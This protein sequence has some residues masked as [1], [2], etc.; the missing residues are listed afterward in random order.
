MSTR[1]TPTDPRGSAR[2]TAAALHREQERGRRRRAALVQG[3]V[4]LALV[5]VVLVATVAVLAARD[6]AAEP[7]AVPSGVGAD[8]TVTVGS[9]DAPVT[10]RLVEDF[11][12]PACGAFEAAVGDQLDTWVESGQVQVEHRPIAFLDRASTTEYSSRALGVALAVLE[13]AGPD[14]YAEVHDLLFASQPPEGGAGLDDERLVDLAVRAGA[15]EAAVAAAAEERPYDAWI[16]EATEAAFEDGVTGT[17]TVL[18]DGEE[19]EASPQALV[20]AVEAALAS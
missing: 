20:A 17:P 6:R 3:G 4:V 1:S 13:D 10:V 18:V 2:E 7:A 9:P 14:A 11:Q 5:A 19:V 16:D 15:D 12:C 8:G